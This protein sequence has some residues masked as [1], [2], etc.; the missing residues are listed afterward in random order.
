MSL[1][2]ILNVVKRRFHITTFK[3]TTNILFNSHSINNTFSFKKFFFQ[4]FLSLK[5]L[6]K[7][8]NPLSILNKLKKNVFMIMLH[9]LQKLPM[10]TDD[11]KSITIAV[12]F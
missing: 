9:G 8:I 12:I 2:C 10:M 7:P 3:D 5:D 4:I 6:S 1:Y 11:D